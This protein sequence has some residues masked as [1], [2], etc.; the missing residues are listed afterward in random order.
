MS[1]TNADAYNYSIA[2]P[3][4]KSHECGVGSGHQLYKTCFGQQPMGLCHGLQA[5]EAPTSLCI[6]WHSLVGLALKL[7]GT[8]VC[9]HR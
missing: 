9:F 8:N 3:G 7:G 4:N 5:A 6:L 1:K 2:Q